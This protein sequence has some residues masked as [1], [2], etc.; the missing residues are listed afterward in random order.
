MT[1]EESKQFLTDISWKL[2]TMG[3][4]YLTEK[5]GEKMREA[6][7]T[8]EQEPCEDA[9][10]RQAVFEIVERNEFK[11]DAL[12]EIEQLPPVQ[13]IRKRGR[14][15]LSGGYWRCTECKGKALLQFD[16]S[17]GGCNEYVPVRSEFCPKCGSDNRED[18]E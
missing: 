6:I 2:G 7:Q 17:K 8:L 1:R 16:K 3:V 5:D 9:I 14:W 12:S 15:I 11:G 18:G 10:S 4:E 13:P